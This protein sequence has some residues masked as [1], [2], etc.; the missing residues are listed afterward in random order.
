LSGE[1]ATLL[2]GRYVQFE[3]KPL[4]FKEF[5]YFRKENELAPFYYGID[6]SAEKIIKRIDN[7]QIE[8]SGKY[9]GD[10]SSFTMGKYYFDDY[11]LL[12]G[13]P[14][15]STQ[16]FGVEQAVQIIKDIHS[17][18]VLKDVILY[19]KIKNV[20]LLEKIVAYFY[21]NV[22]NLTSLRGI[23]EYISGG[24][25]KKA[26]VNLETIGNY[27]RYLE[28]AYIIKKAPRYDIKGK[29]LFETNDKYYLADHSLAYAVK[30]INKV[31]KGAILENI[32]YKELASRGY[33]VCVG[34]FDTK[35]VDFVAE[36]N[37]EKLYIQVCLEFT[38]EDTYKREVAP[39]KA[40]KDNYPKYVVSLDNFAG[41]NDD[42]I[43]G[44]S[45][46]DFLL[47]EAY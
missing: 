42:G 1:L 8:F 25:K 37:G 43:I 44:I 47:K 14:F 26:A 2:S 41:R 45:L 19:N 38:T 33:N 30:D 10:L 31:N 9:G 46:K 27:V 3:I 32:V 22:G 17:S 28:S 4:S 24:D 34:K 35:E 7:N 5:L 13:F 12:G 15:I 11:F 21:D 40:I 16:G 23:A 18:I 6:L 39:L 36:K 20:A 29:K